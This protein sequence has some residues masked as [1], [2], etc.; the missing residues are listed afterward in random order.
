MIWPLLA[1]ASLLVHLTGYLVSPIALLFCEP[2]DE[3]LPWWAWPWDNPQDG[4]NGDGDSTWGWRGPEHANGREREYW[5][6][7]MWLYRNAGYGFAERSGARLLNTPVAVGPD[8]SDQSGVEGVRRVT[9]RA[10]VAGSYRNAWE[11]YIIWRWPGTSRC[12]RIRLGWKLNGCDCGDNAIL[13]VSFS[14]FKAIK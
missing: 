12:V 14:P 6:R 7:L 2:E 9:V 3:H 4:I 8:V 5:W 11:L 1:L 10:I 13:V